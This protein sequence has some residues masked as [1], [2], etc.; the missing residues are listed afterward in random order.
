M[1]LKVISGQAD[2]R[3]DGRTGE[4]DYGFF[5]RKSRISKAS[6]PE[7]VVKA[8]LT[9][10]GGRLLSSHFPVAFASEASEGFAKIVRLADDSLQPWRAVYDEPKARDIA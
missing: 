10:D 3:P 9:S 1:I 7:C 6:L 4:F 2:V 5:Q 8:S